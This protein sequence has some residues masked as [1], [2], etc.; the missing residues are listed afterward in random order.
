MGRPVAQSVNEQRLIGA[1]D[2]LEDP[3]VEVEQLEGARQQ[4]FAFH[5]ERHPT[6]RSHE[7]R[8]PEF[9]LEPRDAPTQRLL[10]DVQPDG[11]PAEMQ[12][13]GNRDE[14]S[15]PSG[16]DVAHHSSEDLAG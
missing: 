13:L 14:H 10:G 15:Q 4:P 3:V 7:Q 12:L 9:A 5:G 11:G 16:I 6:S 1:A 2:L 8:H